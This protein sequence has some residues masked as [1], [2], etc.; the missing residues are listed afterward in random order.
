M[1]QKETDVNSYSY[2]A[3][4]TNSKYLPG[5]EVLYKSLKKTNPKY[6]FHVVIP[7]NSPYRFV[8]RIKAIVNEEE[9]YYCEFFD[10]ENQIH[11]GKYSYWSET[12]FKLN[13]ARLL[14]FSKIVV[15]DLDLLILDNI[16]VLFSYS[17][18]S[19]CI[20]CNIVRKDWTTFNSG[21]LVIEPNPTFYNELVKIASECKKKNQYAEIGDQDIF[22]MYIPDWPQ[23]EELHVP[24]EYN[25]YYRCVNALART[26]PNGWKDIKVIHYWGQKK[27]WEYSCIDLFLFYFKN[28]IK[29]RTDL[30]RCFHLYFKYCKNNNV[31]KKI[32]RKIRKLFRSICRNINW[33]F[34]R[35]FR[36]KPKFFSKEETI[37]YILNNN[38]SVSRFGDGEFKM[39]LGSLNDIGFQKYSNSISNELL[40]SFNTRDP[41][42][43]ICNYNF[44]GEKRINNLYG[45]WLKQYVFDDYKTIKQ[46]FDFKYRY[47]DANITRFYHPHIFY[48]DK[49]YKYLSCKYVPLLM[50][51]WENRNVLIVEGAETKLGVGNNLFDNCKSLRRVV[52]PPKN[53]FEKKH[54]IKETI[55]KYVRPD[56]LVLLSLGPTASILSVEIT[57]EKNIQCI[58]IGHIDVVYMWFLNRAKDKLGIVGKYVNEQSSVKSISIEINYDKY[59]HEIVD[60]IK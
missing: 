5:L 49:D 43:L 26:L 52:C 42:I 28:I 34:F 36:K 46:L 1:F 25:E 50:K 24:E 10:V 45:N 6:P 18:L 39:M 20:S 30:N 22:Q 57:L 58:D 60:E 37:E 59:L 7:S 8:E 41:R 54:Q 40:E 11:H 31:L 48:S 13:A 47:G 23:R 2:I 27:P 12:F 9:I 53:A 19:A 38:A 32:F 51:I 29:L 4:I 35:Y 55:Y 21:V 14:E 33:F 3:F 15:L 44:V 56:D 16:D 17:N